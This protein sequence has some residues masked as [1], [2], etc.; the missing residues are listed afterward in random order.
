MLF[1]RIPKRQINIAPDIGQT[2]CRVLDPEAQDIID[3]A[4]TK[5]HDMTDRRLEAQHPLDPACGLYRQFA[6]HM[7]I[8][9][10]S[11]AEIDIEPHKIVGVGPVHH[12]TGDQ[13]LVRDQIFLPVPRHDRGIARAQGLDPA[14]GI[15]KADHIPRLDRLVDED[16]DPR[17]KVRHD[18]LQA[19]TK[20]HTN[21]PRQHR[22]PGKVNP[23][24][25]DPHKERDAIKRQ[26]YAL[27]RQHLHRGADVFVLADRG[28]AGLADDPRHREEQTDHHQRGDHRQQRQPEI[29]DRQRHRIQKRRD[30][31]NHIQRIERG[32]DPQ[33]P[34]HQTPH[35]AVAHQPRCEGDTDP[36]RHQRCEYAD[37]IGPRRPGDVL[38]HQIDR[39]CQQGE[40]H[41]PQTPLDLHHHAQLPLGPPLA[42]ADP[43]LQPVARGVMQPP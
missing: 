28:S 20:A 32:V 39:P 36:D 24:G 16:D 29:P 38:H 7:G 1:E 35:G 17:H 4:V 23:D 11:R 15:A 14:K 43:V 30:I 8:I 5:A 12:L 19:E 3:A 27:H 42:R 41:Q 18:L 2:A 26:L 33:P 40:P 13:V 37:Q 9:P 21:R 6:H 25:L 31:I 10:V 22:K 34:C